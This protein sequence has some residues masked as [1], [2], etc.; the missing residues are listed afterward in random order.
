MKNYFDKSFISPNAADLE[1]CSMLM[2]YVEEMA[3]SNSYVSA[4]F[5]I[6]PGGFFQS[7]IVINSECG[8]FYSEGHSRSIFKSLKKAQSSILKSIQ[9]WKSDRFRSPEVDRRTKDTL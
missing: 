5:N 4:R 6:M 3:P 7:I 8:R 1:K 9:S 2:S